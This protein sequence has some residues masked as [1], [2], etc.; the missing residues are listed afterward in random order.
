MVSPEIYKFAVSKT[1]V[2]FCLSHV[3]IGLPVGIYFWS[4]VTEENVFVLPTSPPGDLRRSSADA[5]RASFRPTSDRPSDKRVRDKK[6][7]LYTLFP[8]LFR[9]DYP[10]IAGGASQPPTN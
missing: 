5:A 7:N 2:G 8:S 1:D 6:F 4:P 10:D 3:A 9:C